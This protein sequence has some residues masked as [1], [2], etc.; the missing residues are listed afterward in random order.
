VRGWYIEVRLRDQLRHVSA[1]MK[2]Q[3]AQIDEIELPVLKFRSSASMG[4]S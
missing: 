3:V 1:Q 4:E 2:Q